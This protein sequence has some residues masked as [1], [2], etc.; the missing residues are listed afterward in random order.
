MKQIWFIKKRYGWG[1]QLLSD[2]YEDEVEVN[3]KRVTR[4]HESLAEYHRG[5]WLAWRNYIARGARW[6]APE[7]GKSIDP[8]T[9]ESLGVIVL[10]NADFGDKHF[11]PCRLAQEISKVYLGKWK[12]DNIMNRF[13][14]DL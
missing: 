14:C 13:N 8:K 12:K 5:E 11:T 2:Q 9:F 6:V 1:W 3:G 7:P 10:C 4:K